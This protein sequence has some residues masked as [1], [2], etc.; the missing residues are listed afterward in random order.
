MRVLLGNPAAKEASTNPTT[1][2]IRWR[3]LDGRRVTTVQI[4]D[5]YTLLEA[6]ATIT[7]QDG[8]WNN[9]SQG[10]NVDDYTPDWVASDNEA[11]ASLLASH[12]GCPVGRPDDWEGQG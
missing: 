12:F 8:V 3:R 11:L 6:V 5:T 2:A 7:A 10:N 4:P 1:G 9:H